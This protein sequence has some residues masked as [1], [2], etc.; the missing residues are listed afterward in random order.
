[1]AEVRAESEWARLKATLDQRVDS[2]A[3]AQV[4]SP[5]YEERRTRERKREKRRDEVKEVEC[6]NDLKRIA[7]KRKRTKRRKVKDIIAEVGSIA[8]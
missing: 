8:E 4:S 2:L 3:Q 6:M 7:S 1:M 5:G